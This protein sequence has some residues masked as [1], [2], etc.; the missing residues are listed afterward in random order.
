LIKFITPDAE[1]YQYLSNDFD[2]APSVIAFF[3]TVAGTLRNISTIS[4]MTWPIR[5]PGGKRVKR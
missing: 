3:I 5:R 2:L 1:K 4:K